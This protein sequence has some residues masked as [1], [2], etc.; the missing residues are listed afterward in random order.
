[1]QNMSAQKANEILTAAITPGRIAAGE[2]WT[3]DLAQKA[4]YLNTMRYW[5]EQDMSRFD[6]DYAFIRTLIKT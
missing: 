2:N 3:Q 5:D 6:A 4:C 1:M